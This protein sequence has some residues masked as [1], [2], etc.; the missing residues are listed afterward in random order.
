M[1]YM[2]KFIFKHEASLGAEWGTLSGVGEKTF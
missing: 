1:L 2:Y